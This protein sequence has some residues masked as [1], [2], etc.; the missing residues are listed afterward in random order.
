MSEL[1]KIDHLF[2]D[3]TRFPWDVVGLTVPKIGSVHSYLCSTLAPWAE[4]AF[5]DFMRNTPSRR[6]LARAAK[7][8]GGV[9][10]DIFNY[11]E[12]IYELPQSERVDTAHEVLGFLARHRG[13]RDHVQK[14]LDRLW[15]QGLISVPRSMEPR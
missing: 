3:H 13:F 15:R 10:A 4:P 11:C 14:T 12:V 6:E 5:Q 9:I 1:L 8:A 7:A 2:D